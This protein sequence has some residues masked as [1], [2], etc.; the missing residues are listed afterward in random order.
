MPKSKLE[1]PK[2]QKNL[3]TVVKPRSKYRANFFVPS[4]ELWQDP[5]PPFIHLCIQFHTIGDSHLLHP[6]T[7]LIDRISSPDLANS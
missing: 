5:L 6:V 2:N 4:S 7:T 3:K 1:N